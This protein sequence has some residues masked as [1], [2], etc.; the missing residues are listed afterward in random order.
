[1]QKSTYIFLSVFFL[2]TGC[3]GGSSLFLPNEPN[4]VDPPLN[5]TQEDYK[6]L[7][8]LEALKK[9]SEIDS[10]QVPIPSIAP[11]LAMPEEPKV[12]STKL[13]SISVTDDVP[14]KEVLL[15]LA[16][17]ADIDM[18]IDANIMGGVALRVQD[19][20][21]NEVIQRISNLANLRYRMENGV[22]RVEQDTPFV[23]IYSV[24]FLNIDR[25][26]TGN[27]TIS[28]N[29]LSGGGGDSEGGGG[30]GLN[31]GSQA[32]ITSEAQSDFWVQFEAGIQQILN[33]NPV[34]RRSRPQLSM[35][36]QLTN[37]NSESEEDAG[38][39]I[40]NRQ[41]STLTV[42]ATENQHQLLKRFLSRVQQ[43]VSAQVLIE[44]KIVEVTLNEQFESGID[45]SRLGGDSVSFTS[46]FGSVADLSN[47]ASISVIGDE[48][49]GEGFNLTAA[50]QLAEQFGTART[51]SSP[52]LHAVNNQQAALTFAENQ[53]YFQVSVEREDEDTASVSQTTLTVDSEIQTVPIGIILTL[54]P[55]INLETREIT[56]SVRPT[57]S[58]ITSFVNDPAVAFILAGVPDTNI[59][60]RVPVVEVRELDSIL[61]IKSGEVMVIGGLM[62]DNYI[63]QDTGIPYAREVPV[64]GNFFKG[65]DKSYETKELIIFIKATIM[66]SSGYVQDA[67]KAIYNTFTKDPRPLTF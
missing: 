58:R 30:G 56:L 22:L 51:L 52:R 21:F 54:Q 8:D 63:N 60:S 18:E 47:V 2:V 64:L 61:K 41:A 45:W 1:M 36:Q 9:K 15:E 62:E 37:G 27:V 16:R 6:A 10:Q 67:D 12:G 35:E 42:S 48:I 65:A 14:L 57:L 53:V 46:S 59:E 28:T 25:S 39:Y 49:L 50:V 5:L 43:N 34:S 33:Y 24:D 66:D 7:N 19:R 3:D 11:I 55:S 31:T 40:L 26:S 38:F 44:A 32:T 29:V 4:K 23:E 17:L 20:P 13:V